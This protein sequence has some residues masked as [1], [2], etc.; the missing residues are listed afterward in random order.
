MSSILSEPAFHPDSQSQNSEGLIIRAQYAWAHFELCGCE[1][2]LKHCSN[3][4][5]SS[6]GVVACRGLPGGAGDGN[7]AATSAQ[8]V[9]LD[10]PSHFAGQKHLKGK[11]V[12]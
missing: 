12:T 4:L 8:K 11:C 9:V 10:S 7:G 3:T 2:E 1:E 6:H 5:S